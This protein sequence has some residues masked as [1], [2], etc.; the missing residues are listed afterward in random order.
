[1]KTSLLV[2]PL[3]ILAILAVL[4]QNIGVVA[5]NDCQKWTEARCN[6]ANLCEDYVFE[7][8]SGTTTSIATGYVVQHASDWI[9]SRLIEG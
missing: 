2:I 1:M 4:T 8:C 7:E 6:E 9:D 5:A 3:V